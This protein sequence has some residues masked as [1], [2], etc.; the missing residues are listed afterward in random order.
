MSKTLI[1]TAKQVSGTVSDVEISASGTNL[2]LNVEVVGLG[3][4]RK[5]D[6]TLFF[7][8]E[9]QFTT[10]DSSTVHVLS[11]YQE[12]IKSDSFVYVDTNNVL[13][14]S[15][16]HNEV[17]DVYSHLEMSDESTTN[18]IFYKEAEFYRQYL[19]ESVVS[20]LI[21]FGPNMNLLDSTFNSETFNYSASLSRTDTVSKVETVI[22]NIQT[23]FA[24]VYVVPD[25]VGTRYTFP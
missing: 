10:V 12:H 3:E 17:V 20:E 1:V 16:I 23:Y 18:D 7:Y 11:F 8:S 22:G 24:G 15:I 6:P 21:S 25:Y 13:T 19:D 5:Y 2:E 4:E 9:D 14:D